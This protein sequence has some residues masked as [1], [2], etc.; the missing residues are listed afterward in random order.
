M[1]EKISFIKEKKKYS[2]VEIIMF[3]YKIYYVT[4]TAREKRKM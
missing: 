2:K 3:Q 4:L 1:N